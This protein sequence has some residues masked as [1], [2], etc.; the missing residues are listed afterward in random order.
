MKCMLVLSI[1]FLSMISVDCVGMIPIE[2]DL[3]YQIESKTIYVDDVPGEG[4]DNPYE[5]YITIQDAIDN[6]NSGDLIFVHNGTYIENLIINKSIKLHGSSKYNTIID[7]NNISNTISI[8]ASK[9]NI[10]NLKI[11]NGN[12]K[13][14]GGGIYI[15]NNHKTIHSISL[16]NC[17]IKNNNCGIILSNCNNIT[18][19][20][21]NFQSNKQQSILFEDSFNDINI[22]QNTIVNNGERLDDNLYSSGGIHFFGSSNFCSNINISSSIIQGNQDAG[23]FLTN[24][25]NVTIFNNT[26]SNNSI[27]GIIILD[28]VDVNCLNNVIEN[29]PTGVYVA[30]YGP[31]K[32]NGNIVFK[33]NFISTTC[34]NDSTIF[35][36]A[37]FIMD[38][39]GMITIILNNISRSSKGILLLR[40]NGINILKNNF[41]DND[42]D[43]S[44]INED[45]NQNVIWEKN[46]WNEK[47]LLPFLI[48]GILSI[49][50]ILLP[51]INVDWHPATEPFQIG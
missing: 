24:V 11:I 37:I 29:N 35:D 6:A 46:Y 1:I 5:D 36:S 41:I 39:S 21:C 48:V 2:Y 40:S 33:K 45:I 14:G 27:K 13:L 34:S 38:Y 51:W 16:S 31:S 8:N 10:F 7:G 28:S 26:I 20:K 17:F 18:I 19:L 32:F 23:I 15:S 47:R 4:Y 12:L 30:A 50:N 42:F 25:S 3:S 22:K 9:V 43:A 49:N 44:F